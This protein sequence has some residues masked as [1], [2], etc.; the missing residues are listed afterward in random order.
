MGSR[1]MSAQP[2]PEEAAEEGAGEQPPKKGKA[3]RLVA[4]AG[5]L[6]GLLVA[7]KVTGVSELVTIA[8]MKQ[9]M[10]DAG[11]W[12]VVLFAVAFVVGEL[13]Q[14]PGLLF[15]SVGVISYGPV[16]GGVLSFMIAVVSVCFSF[17]IVRLVGGKALGEMETPWVKKV[18]ARLD[19]R[20]IVTISL[21]R[22]VLIMAPQL[23]YALALTNVRF[24]DYL[25]GSV[26]GLLPPIAAFVVFFDAATS[27]FGFQ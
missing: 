26:I 7:A 11:A 8:N 18:M 27:L 9:W 6:I 12:G 16:M 22:V 19:R 25:I 4:V 17:V 14:V 2:E 1:S 10:A 23:N 15:V 5:L 13:L 20:P 24:R 21:L 3:L